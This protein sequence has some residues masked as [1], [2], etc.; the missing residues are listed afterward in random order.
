[1]V[2]M[3]GELVTNREKQ[4]EGTERAREKV[5]KGDR[6]TVSQTNFDKKQTDTQNTDRRRQAD[7]ETW[8]KK[9]I[10]IILEEKN[11]GKWL[12]LEH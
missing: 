7:R 6:Q 11:A 4:K 1:M 12:K 8:T 9:D 2:E 10:E 5:T 3:V